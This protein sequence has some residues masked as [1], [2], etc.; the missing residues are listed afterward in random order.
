MQIHQTSLKLKETSGYILLWLLNRVAS[1]GQRFCAALYRLSVDAIHYYTQSDKQFNVC[2][3]HTD[4]Q[5]Q[6][7]RKPYKQHNK[8]KTYSI[9]YGTNQESYLHNI[10]AI[11]IAKFLTSVIYRLVDML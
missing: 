11:H 7:Q 2:Q 5:A 3:M 9:K 10:V 8:R 1:K 4:Y 6:E